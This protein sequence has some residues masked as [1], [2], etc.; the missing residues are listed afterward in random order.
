MPLAG[1]LSSSS[2]RRS[3]ATNGSGRSSTPF[4]SVNT[5]VV[6]PMP[7]A[8]TSTTGPVRAGVV[9]STRAACLRSSIN[10]RAC[11]RGAVVQRSTSSSAQSATS[12]R[13]SDRSAWRSRTSATIS[14]SYSWR[15]GAGYSR[16]RRR[17]QRTERESG[18][19]CT[20]GLRALRREA[21]NPRLREQSAEP[22]GFSNGR[23]APICRDPVEA[24]ALV[25]GRLRSTDLLDQALLEHPLD[26]PV[27]RPRAEAHAAVGERR[28][29]LHHAVPVTL[30]LGQGHR[31]VEDDVRK[32]PGRG[33]PVGGSKH[34]DAAR[35][36]VR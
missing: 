16:V 2:T 26:G 30:V 25:G 10:M 34:H 1:A 35:Y 8:S 29:L 21:G 14:V 36:T 24:A 31:D 20:P 27:Q 32:R 17:Y 4:A 13:A 5:A 28:H 33:I 15:N 18:R 19:S 11:S 6:A 22:F 7:T 23:A 12:A 3:A 9:R